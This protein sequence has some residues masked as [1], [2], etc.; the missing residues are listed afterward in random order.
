MQP[1]GRTEINVD[2]TLNILALFSVPLCLILC[3]TY[4]R[5]RLL[6]LRHGEARMTQLLDENVDLRKRIEVLETIVTA[7]TPAPLEA[8]RSITRRAA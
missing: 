1:C 5:T 3:R 7:P 2:K 8:G 6:E 4:V